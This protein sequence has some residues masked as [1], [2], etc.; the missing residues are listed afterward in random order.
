MIAL[1]D[2][3]SFYCS[4]ERVFNPKL[5][6]QPVVVL[7][8]NDGCVVA[9]SSEVKALGIP[10]GVPF[11]KIREQVKQHHIY[12]FSSNY[13]LYGDLSDR[14]MTVLSQFTPA[15][16]IYSIDEAF[17]NLAGFNH[18]DLTAY[19]SQICSTVKQ[20]TGIPVS[21]GIA[22]TKVLAKV[23]GRVAKKSPT[24]VYEM[25]TSDDEILHTTAVEDIWGIGSKLSQ[26]LHHQGIPTA[27][28]LRDAHPGLIRKKMGIIGIRLQQELQGIPCLPL[29][30]C[31]PPKKETTV[32]RSFGR[33]VTTQQELKEAVALYTSRAAEKLRRQ[34]QAATVIR[35]FARSS[36]FGAEH[37]TKSR[38]VELGVAT[39]DTRELVQAALQL[40]EAIFCEGVS[41]QKAGVTM[42][43][44][45]PR[46]GIQGSL[47]DT[48]AREGSQRLMA[49]IDRINR[50]FGSGT[51]QVAAAGMQRGWEMRRELRSPCFTTCWGELPCVA[52][53]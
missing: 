45:V 33:P 25:P 50:R 5:H 48:A 49:T 30:Q 38:T 27:L 13:A 11:F 16:E 35:V 51:I 47:F 24:G 46:D 3:N 41:F 34:Q 44:L 31:P 36:P 9:R 8:N 6:N 22:P 17:L 39:S 28:Q 26:W 15:M 19:G 18:L 7:S 2:C 1:I 14:V 43:G 23:A 21:V 29:E 37:Y 40:V 42:M 53:G 52:L 4:C 10:M 12:V 32:S 20:W